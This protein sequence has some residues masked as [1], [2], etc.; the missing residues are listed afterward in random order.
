MT[1]LI[2]R[3]FLWIIIPILILTIPLQISGQTRN[4][5]QSGFRLRPYLSTGIVNGNF[6]VSGQEYFVESRQSM[7]CGLKV[8]YGLGGGWAGLSLGMNTGIQGTFGSRTITKHKNFAQHEDSPDYQYQQGMYLRQ[9]ITY[10]GPSI[11][12]KSKNKPLAFYFSFLKSW[13]DWD[14][15]Q[16]DDDEAE[17]WEFVEN[18]DSSMGLLV[19]VSYRIITLGY[20]FHVSRAEL[21]Q[22]FPNQHEYRIPI[23]S[24]T[25]WIH[26]GLLL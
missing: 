22:I 13:T 12:F 9:R 19:S 14:T 23:I 17:G 21:F 16:F 4:S 15:N 10:W 3:E 24:R 25:N 8:L 20:S 11:A 2:K 18:R 1:M 26:I 7:V 6:E 5:T